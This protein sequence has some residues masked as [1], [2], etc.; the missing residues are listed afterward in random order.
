MQGDALEPGG[1]T[2][3]GA[4]NPP[5]PAGGEAGRALPLAFH[6]RAGE[7]FRIWIVNLCL[8]LLTLGIYSPWAKVRKKRYFYSRTTLDDTPFQY[9]ARPLPI[10]KGRLVALA[11]FL[12]W[13]V[14]SHFY[15]VALP[16]VVAAGFVVAPW[17]V[18]R[19]AAFNAR[20]SA[21]RNLTFDFDDRYAT[22]FKVLNVFGLV[23]LAV[24]VAIAVVQ[25]DG[26]AYA[27]P[28]AADLALLISVG[29]VLFPWWQ[30][31]LRAYLVGG[32]HYGGQRARFGARTA[33]YY[34]IYLL[35]GWV[36]VVGTVAVI[37][38]LYLIQSLIPAGT[39]L[40]RDAGTTARALVGLVAGYLAYAAA[41]TLVQV[42]LANLN[43]NHTRLG[44]LR[45]HSDLPAP[46]MFRL[47]VTNALGIL[48]S[49]G[50]LIPWAVVRTVRYRLDHLTVTTTG[51]WEGFTGTGRNTA[52]AAGAEV[53]EFF[54]MDLSL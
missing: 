3:P 6:G 26:G 36:L 15:T 25:Y 30:R 11:L 29:L 23:P 27:S 53:S 54:D 13:Y 18:A 47:Y 19:S 16:Y 44:P 52:T 33:S 21:F 40:P 35:A 17:V 24:V 2:P 42:K 46:G 12:V 43:W 1:R 34:G 9:L 20:Y 31:R 5:A 28:G 14:S 45:F 38:L 7:Y 22:A 51:A 50:L 4:G 32:V 10:L 37:S 48:A 41:Y 39:A 8:T 49:A